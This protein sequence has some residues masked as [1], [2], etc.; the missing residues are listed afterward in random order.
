M[1]NFS[2]INNLPGLAARQEAQVSGA[3][4]Q[5]T[6]FRISSGLRLRTG[7]DD[8]A[9]L[10]IA[11]NLKAQYRTLGQSIRNAN[12]GVGFLQTADSALGQVSNLLTRAASL[13]SQAASL[14]SKDGTEMTAITNELAQLFQEIDRIG[15]G[16]KFGGQDVFSGETKNIFVGDTQ[17]NVGTANTVSSNA[18]ISASVS[19]L[20]TNGLGITDESVSGSGSAIA[21]AFDA[22]EGDKSPVALLAQVATAIDAVASERGSIGAAINR[23][24][25]AVGVMQAQVQNLTAAESQIR[26]AN[27][28]EEIA[29]MTKFQ[30]LSQTGIAALAQANAQSQSVLALFR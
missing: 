21:V 10:A 14:N 1:G 15:G 26:D 4:L 11:D 12:D 6:L 25:N 16:T 9:G 23:L 27:M 13:L 19:A 30:I 20:T 24:E 2:V 5:K 8:A 7:G 18:Q 22:M 3:N 29:N 28:A 17:N